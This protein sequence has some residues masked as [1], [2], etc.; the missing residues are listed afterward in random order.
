VVG[1]RLGSREWALDVSLWLSNRVV[2]NAFQPCC[3][4]LLV[5]CTIQYNMPMNPN[6]S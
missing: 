6:R 5:H 3:R 4:D 1:D 2:E